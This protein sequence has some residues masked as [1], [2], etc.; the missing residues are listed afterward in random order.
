LTAPFLPEVIRPEGRSGVIFLCDHASN[1]IPPE[2]DGL[3]LDPAVLDR[4]VAW[5]IGAAEVTRRLAGAFNAPAVLTTVSRLVLDVNRFLDDPASMPGRSDGIEVPGNRR[6]DATEHQARAARIFHPYHAAVDRRITALVAA[7]LHPAVVSVHS[8]TDRMDGRHRPWHIGVLHALNDRLAT[9][10][11][12]RL[13]GVRGLVVGD[14]QPYSLK[15][16]RGYTTD[17]HAERRGL[18]YVALEIRQDLIATPDGAAIMAGLIAAAL[19]AALAGL[20]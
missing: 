12:G 4:H 14:N 3:G 9:P 8:C 19:S 7:G 11:L 15:T 16:M 1:H 6:A 17:I 13:R 5:D 10:L 20:D 18:P 2:Y